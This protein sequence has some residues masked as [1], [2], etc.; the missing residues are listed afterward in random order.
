MKKLLTAAGV[1][2]LVMTATP[3]LVAG[4]DVFGLSPAACEES[5]AYFME[6]RL[7]D[8]RSARIELDGD[9]YKVSVDLRGG[10]K[11]DAWA[12][13]VLVKSRLPS[14]SW[15][16]YQPYT[17]IFQNGQAVALESDVSDMTV[18]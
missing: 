10:Q 15:S 3:G 16:N 11:V 14:G 13:D 4:D 7:Y 9:P 12:Q 8:S 1:S 6:D 2:L 17:V 18:I 5:V